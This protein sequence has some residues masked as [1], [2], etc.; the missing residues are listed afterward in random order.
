MSVSNN[1][2]E[3]V[4]FLK[5]REAYADVLAAG[6]RKHLIHGLVEVDVTT[7]RLRLA[8]LAAAGLP[9]SFT[10]FVAHAIATAVEENRVMHAYRRRSRLVLFDDVDV[11]VQLEVE[12]A[13]QRQVKPLIVRAANRKD[14]VEIS[15]EIQ[16]ARQSRP[17]D[18]RL[19]HETLALAAVPHP[20]RTLGWRAVMAH[21]QWVKRFGGTVGLSSV[22]MFGPR[23]GWGIPIA[24]PTLM[25]TLGG[26]A[27]RPRY[28]DGELE[29]RQVLH[30]TITVDHTIVDGAPAA[31]FA[32][33]L[34]E[35]IEAAHDLDHLD[36]AQPRGAPAPSSAPAATA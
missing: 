23:G 28:V 21:P 15:A 19:Y 35:L 29:P 2:Y 36:P 27:T 34:S 24:P 9:L 22:G 13:G 11:N 18:E 16:A 4:P 6:R 20:L 8:A 17:E 5:V 32:R 1:S 14:V 7:A 12:I 30:L 26:I 25:I 3:T 31:R 10:G 33:R